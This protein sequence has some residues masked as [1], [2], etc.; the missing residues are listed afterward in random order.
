MPGRL[1]V[2]TENVRVTDYESVGDTDIR[3]SAQVT[4]DRDNPTFVGHYPGLPVFP[5]VC[6][7]DCV[8]RTVLAAA[9]IEGVTPVLT[10]MS[11][12][13]FRH[14]VSPCDEIRIDTAIA[15]ADTEWRVDGTLHG[16]RGPVAR[17]RLRYRLAEEGP[18]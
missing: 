2:L 10:T 9:E 4:V 17:V 5:G 6:Q 1:A 7:V 13:R 3:V 11:M 14:V 8:H 12:A 16:Q 15:R 18:S